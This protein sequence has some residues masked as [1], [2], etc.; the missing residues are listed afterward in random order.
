MFL[1]DTN[2]L[3]YASEESASHHNWARR[4]NAQA[5]AAD[6]ALTDAV[7]LTELGVGEED[8]AFK[9]ERIRSWGIRI[10]GGPVAA[11]EVCAAVTCTTG[12]KGSGSLERTRRSCPFQTS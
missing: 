3:I 1:L 7:C 12:K 9:A 11:T 10:L 6:G 2:V 5:V 8:P 4:T